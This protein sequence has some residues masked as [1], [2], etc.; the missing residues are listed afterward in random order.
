M[1]PCHHRIIL[2]GN[3][4]W[5]D[6]GDGVLGIM[7]PSGYAAK[8]N[9]LLAQLVPWPEENVVP[10]HIVNRSPTPPS[11]NTSV[12]SICQLKGTALEKLQLQPT[13]K[14]EERAVNETDSFK[15]YDLEAMNRT[16]M[17]KNKLVCLE[18]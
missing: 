3:F 16:S 4:R 11:Q 8:H 13:C 14:Q 15:Q 10:I 18:D 5:A 6:C 9:L 12:R 2:L 7:Q 17:Q 1:I